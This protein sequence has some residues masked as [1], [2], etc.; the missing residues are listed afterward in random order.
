[1]GVLLVTS[2]CGVLN[3]VHLVQIH[4]VLNAATRP[5]HEILFCIGTDDAYHL[6]C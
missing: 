5:E 4:A 1:M 2:F 6:S 3:A